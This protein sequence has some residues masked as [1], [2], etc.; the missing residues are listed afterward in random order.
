MKTNAW[1][2]MTAT[3]THLHLKASLTAYEGDQIVFERHYDD[4][5][6]RRFV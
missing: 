3:A 1:A 6:A 5:V 2:E 4:K